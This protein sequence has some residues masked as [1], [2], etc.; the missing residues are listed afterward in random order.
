MVKIPHVKQANIHYSLQEEKQE[1][2]RA[3]R[4]KEF[5]T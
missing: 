1:K 4:L 2:N 3:W 5:M